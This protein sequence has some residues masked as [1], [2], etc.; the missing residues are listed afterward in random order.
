M[1]QKLQKFEIQNSSQILGG[2]MHRETNINRRK[3]ADKLHNKV[4]QLLMS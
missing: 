3:S 1:I 4:T 2:D